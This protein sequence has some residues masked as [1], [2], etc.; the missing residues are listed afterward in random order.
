MTNKNIIIT[1]EDQYDI[2]METRG[3]FE[4]GSSKN[5]NDINE[6][7]KE[8]ICFEDFKMINEVMNGNTTLNIGY[9]T[10]VYQI[11][12]KLFS[13]ISKV[14]RVT[15]YKATRDIAYIDIYGEPSTK[16]LECNFELE[17]SKGVTIKCVTWYNDDEW[18]LEELIVNSY[19]SDIKV[20]KNTKVEYAYIDEEPTHISEIVLYSRTL[21]DLSLDVNET[22]AVLKLFSYI[23]ELLHGITVDVNELL[24]IHERGTKIISDSVEILRHVNDGIK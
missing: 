21:E 24:Q 4:K 22:G 1:D 15:D 8:N 6:L 12:S 3:F 7:I 20:E 17:V 14:I 18:T 23:E 9:A 5:V 16:E 13:F 19:P 2:F 11:I 10:E